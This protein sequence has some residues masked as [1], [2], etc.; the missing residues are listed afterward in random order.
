MARRQRERI[1]T[2][3]NLSDRNE[4]AQAQRTRQSR[5]ATLAV[6]PAVGAGTAVGAAAVGAAAVG[7]AASAAAD[8]GRWLTAILR[9]AGTLDKAA[10][11]GLSKS[12]GHLASS[13]N[14]V[15]VDLSAAVVTS[16]RAFARDLLAPARTFEEDGQC[17]LLLGASPDLTAELDR[18]AVPVIT[19]AADTPTPPL[20]AA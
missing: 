18:L 8:Q 6:A 17:L 5:R 12:L 11:R 2:I 1:M 19:L 13:S 16:P 4:L 3:Q 9:P 15:I 14:M 10:L 20:Q 7:A